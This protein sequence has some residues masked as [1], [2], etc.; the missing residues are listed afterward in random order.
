MPAKLLTLQFFTTFAIFLASAGGAI[1][2]NA[3]AKKPRTS[4]SPPLV[5]PTTVLVVL[6]ALGLLSL[7]HMLSMLGLHK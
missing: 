6:L 4:L 3:K 5:A 1:F 7:I 2:I